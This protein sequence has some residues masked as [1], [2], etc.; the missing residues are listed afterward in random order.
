[1]AWA[2]LLVATPAYAL[3]GGMPDGGDAVAAD[4]RAAAPALDASPLPPRDG[5][6]GPTDTA[7]ALAAVPP[8][9]S[10]PSAMTPS[11]SFAAPSSG[12]DVVVSASRPALRD[13][14]QDATVMA[15]ERV[16]A[17]TRSTLF[18]ALAQEAADVYVP[19][20]G[21]GLHGVANGATGGI[22]IRGLGG[23]PNTQVLVVE[24]GVPDYQGIFG[25]PIP[26]AYLPHLL[27][28]VLV[29]KG[30]DSTLYG[31]NA[32][33][34]VV[35]L[36]NRW[37]SRD[38]LELE[39]DSGGG[40]YRTL[41]QSL[42]VLGRTGA[43]DV[44]GALTL[45]STQGHRDGAG[46]SSLAGTTALSYRFTPSLRLTLRNK[47]VHV[48]GGDPG[49]TSHPTPD[50]WFDVWRDTVS[51]QLAYAAGKLRLAITPYLNV[52]IHRLYDGFYSRD[53]VGG[54]SGELQARLHP[55]AILLV[56]LAG[57]RVDGRVEDRVAGEAE[58]VR[59]FGSAALYGQVTLRPWMPLTIVLGSR[60]LWSSAYGLV[61]LYKAGAR[62]DLGRGFYAH[63]R[64]SRNFRQP[65]IRELYLPYPVANPALKPEYAVSSELGVGYLSGRLEIACTAY[66]T[67]AHALIKYFGAWPTAEVINLDHVVVRGIEGRVAVRQLGPLSALLAAD[68]QDVGRYTRQNPSAKI[69]FTVDARQRFGP[70]QLAAGLSGEW[71]HGLYMAD[72]GRYP[73]AD[74]FFMD[75]ALRYRHD[76]TTTTPWL[77]GLEPYILLR[78][79][80]DRRYAYVG[81]YMPGSNEVAAYTMPGFNV[82]A[83]LRFTP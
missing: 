23:S 30:G 77:H 28:D 48:Q 18:D 56:G 33:A 19:G 37:A 2:A 68:W 52:G 24:D 71:V 53:Y 20:R 60:G 66:R 17:S 7:H 15:G 26:D 43:W 32:M 79:L 45:F 27:E 51:A 16:R 22:K 74:V 29:V 46:G 8:P 73:M 63:G 35:V 59:G 72:Y 81:A 80:L 12:S 4:T 62:W 47:V 13:R 55:S 70:H 38:G 49:T 36:R 1:L 54:G 83:G 10:H 25:H 44:A 61:P 58:A 39:V 82:F 76:A 11:P 75:L 3:D 67:E 34:G 57:D 65:T 40:S 41:R 78:N 42:S 64:V 6:S 5:G 14:T 69:N 50:H 21:L 9:P 31:T